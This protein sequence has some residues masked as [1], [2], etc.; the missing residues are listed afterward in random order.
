MPHLLN[1]LLS[2]AAVAVL[3]ALVA[4]VLAQLWNAYRGGRPATA[5]A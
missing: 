5:A 1:S 3:E 2:Q 4:R